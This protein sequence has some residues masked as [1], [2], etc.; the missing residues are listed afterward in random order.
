MA[1]SKSLVDTTAVPE[2]DL[3]IFSGFSFIEEDT[4]EDLFSDFNLIE[5]LPQE[6]EDIIDFNQFSFSK[7]PVDA[8]K[9]EIH[10][11]NVNSFADV[12]ADSW[13]VR[14]PQE[15]IKRD[16]GVI[17]RFV[18]KFME[19][20]VPVPMDV[21]SGVKPPTEWQDIAAE[22][23]GT[24]LG[25]GASFYTGAGLL[26]GLKIVGTGAK[27][28]MNLKKASKA[29]TEIASLRKRARAS[30]S[31]AYKER[32]T[33]KAKK[34]EESLD[35]T[36]SEAGVLRNNS[37]LGRQPFYEKLITKIGADDIKIKGDYGIGKFMAN[38]DFVKASG[39]EMAIR[40]ANY[41]NYGLTNLAGA[42]W[43]FQKTIPARDE[44]GDLI[45]AERIWKPALDAMFMSVGGVPRIL[46]GGKFGS[47]S[48]TSGATGK[49]LESTLVFATGMGA[50][51]A[52]IGMF[53]EGERTIGENLIDGA[54]FTAAHYIG[55]GADNMRIKH[56]VRE[57][58]EA[59][60][61]D[62][63]VQKDIAKAMSG[64][65]ID[66]IK[67][68]MATKR[69]E[70]LRRR[71][72]DKRNPNRLVQFDKITKNKKGD[73]TLVYTYLTDPKGMEGQVVTI[74]GRT[75]QEVLSHFFKRYRNV[76]PNPKKF[77]KRYLEKNPNS[78]KPGTVLRRRWKDDYVEHQKIVKSIKSI[79]DKIGLTGR[80]SNLLRRS[81]FRKSYGN[82][83][84]MSIEQLNLYKEM[85]NPKRTIKDIRKA[86]IDSVMPFELPDNWIEKQKNFSGIRGAF[87]R[88]GLHPANNVAQWGASGI[89]LSRRM[90]DL[91]D[92]KNVVR[93]SFQR[94]VTDVSSNF[95][96]TF[97]KKKY[98]NSITALLGDEKLNK[99]ADK[100]T[101]LKIGDG[102][103]LKQRVRDL[104]DETFVDL[105]RNNVKIRVSENNFEPL[106]KLYG[107][108]GKVIKVSE[109]SF[110]N[111]DVLRLLRGKNNKVFNKNGKKV[112]VDV[113]KSME[114]SAYVKDYVPRYLSEQGRKLL[115]KDPDS[116]QDNLRNAVM[117]RN[118][119][120]SQK[121]VN[122]I[123]DNYLD[124]A[125]S[126]KP[127]GI[128]NTRKIDIPPY[129]IVEKGSK[130][131]IQLD[132]IPDLSTI[133][134][135][136]SITDIDG[137]KR[138]VGEI[139][140][141]YEKDF[142]KIF[143]N[144]T[145]QASLSMALF[146][147]FD[148]KGIKSDRAIKYFD[149][150][151]KQY[152]TQQRAYAQEN[153]KLLIGGQPENAWSKVGGIGTTG[154]ANLYLSG[155]SAVIKNLLTGQT[156]NFMA[157]GTRKLLKGYKNYLIKHKFYKEMTDNV[158]GLSGN[159]DEL[160]FVYKKYPAKAFTYLS[161][162]FRWI[163]R[164]NRRSSVAIADVATRDAYDS[165]LKNKS[166]IFWNGAKEARK[167]LKLSMSMD[168]K[169]IDYMVKAL[170]KRKAYGDGAFDLALG[171]DRKF[172]DLYEHGLYKSQ[173][174]TQGVTQ[175]PYIPTW[176]ANNK[177]KPLT[178]F[179]RTAYR[180]TEN[181]YNRA[182]V[183]FV[184]DG[185]PFP[186]MRYIGGATVSGKLLYD[187]YYGHAL[188]KDLLDKNFKEAPLEYFDLAVRG[189]ALGL[190]SNIAD[191][192]GGVL[193]SYTPVLAQFG[194]E[195]WNVMKSTPSL[196]FEDPRLAVKGLVDYGLRNV[197][198]AKQAHDWYRTKNGD[199]NK[200]FENQ[201]RLMSQFARQYPQFKNQ[202]ER[203]SFLEIAERGKIEVQPF[204]Y[205][206]LS[207][208]LLYGD[209]EQFTSDFIKTRA[210]LERK[211]KELK[212]DQGKDF[213]LGEVR[214]EVHESINN[215]L[216]Q[217]L[218]PYPETWEVPL[219][220]QKPFIDHFKTMISPENKKEL[221]DLLEIYNKRI[222][223]LDRVVGLTHDQYQ[224]D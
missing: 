64:D 164:F 217:S 103:L 8:T 222:R 89:K 16:P 19:A 131:I 25:Y 13:F 181:T 174:A 162:P 133:K 203:N 102:K 205:D 68:Y 55:V 199:I 24:I 187:Y 113:S 192:H 100:A 110:D 44:T 84:N 14:N 90:I 161:A 112:I 175:L 154:V 17:P 144:Y 72:V 219:H 6:D 157:H 139:I 98:Y 210:F 32:L 27:T 93:G 101:A 218:R 170:Q 150:I 120:A 197:T 165:I 176:M 15:E 160:A 224:G 106:L 7:E 74:Q 132:E 135:G 104:F 185:N 26:G 198:V 158:G 193:E 30:K 115:K 152:G 22:L 163:E 137:Q 149:D 38:V 60:I 3:G 140:E 91:A 201:R 159:I 188:G 51:Q 41:L 71:F 215:S 10:K 190:F 34:M 1:H 121:E 79:E 206:L 123:V 18:G 42:S 57:G 216:K 155:P 85:I 119:G 156:Q 172:R 53:G 143:E 107:Q 62:K 97:N 148:E 168:D 52:G 87:R 65:A 128:L 151:A 49:A 196:A 182:I 21:S 31:L 5:G 169:G 129:M 43:A 12:E 78:L 221:E 4:E 11:W 81:A 33:S 116:F 75:E 56:A 108:N 223:L 171:S 124:F 213:Y 36:L 61:D 9:S 82:T 114:E 200:R 136:M 208:S 212:A 111:G 194:Q 209:E 204:Y 178:L 94:F 58:L 66:R 88:F 195:T 86:T 2:D 180:V 214:A 153:L 47:F 59:V 130:R 45:I 189:E 70:F 220:G 191:E 105:A 50:S 48:L 63:R 76:L 73:H 39:D 20:Y 80:E 207:Q 147:N 145:N 183:P 29:Y 77:S 99:I 35:Q 173:A 23:S 177:L 167:A 138:V 166:S 46:A 83:D 186:M 146:K 69:P 211:R 179:Y 125:E 54:I 67:L 95:L 134:K 127:L 109:K 142:G 141:I 40:A 202:E 122:R 184:R 117:A 96:P 92:T 118:K 126:N 37:I 28:T